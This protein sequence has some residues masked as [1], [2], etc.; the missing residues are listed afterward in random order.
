MPERAVMDFMG[1]SDSTM[2]KRYTHVVAA[3][4]DDIASRI[5]GLLWKPAD[6]VG[7]M[8]NHPTSK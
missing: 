3:L 1:W 2:V 6:A 7:T 4:R 5:N 8:A